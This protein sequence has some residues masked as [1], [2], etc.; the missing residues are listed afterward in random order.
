MKWFLLFLLMT[1]VGFG[2]AFYALYRQDRTQFMVRRLHSGGAGSGGGEGR[3][4]MRKGL[5]T[6]SMGTG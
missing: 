4:W 6:L 1:L 5:G 2:L 3:A